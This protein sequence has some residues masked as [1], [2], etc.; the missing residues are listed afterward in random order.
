MSPN[1]IQG[2]L[3]SIQHQLATLAKYAHGTPRERKTYLEYKAILEGKIAA[4]TVVDK[5]VERC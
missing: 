4:L 5:P 3:Y 2:R 1:E